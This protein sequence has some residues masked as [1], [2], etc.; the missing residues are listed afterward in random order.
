MKRI[1]ILLLAA[2]LVPVLAG[3]LSAQLP[4][5]GIKG[6]V[7]MAN[8]SGSDDS[9]DMKLGAIGGAFAC[10]DLIALK[11]QPEILFSQKG[12]KEDMSIGGITYTLST[13]EN[14][15]E[16]PVLLKYSFGAVVVPSIYAGP[17]FGML[18]SATANAS[19]SG[20]SGSTDIK[21]YLN[22][23]DIGLVIGAEVKM[24]MKL[25]IEARYNMGLTKVPKEVSG[26]QP[27][28]KNSTISV[29]LGYYIF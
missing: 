21:N 28:A 17:S 5:F 27:D 8:Y 20:V 23:T 1:T 6:G 7:N 29:M 19:G 16:I 22:G 25:S 26:Y 11:I 14:Y 13:T 24:P 9:G 3:N 4:S 10:V 15:I 18:M 12:A 2:V